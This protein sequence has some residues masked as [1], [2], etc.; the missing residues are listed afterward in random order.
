MSYMEKLTYFAVFESCGEGYSVYFPDL[1]GCISV[2]DDLESAYAGAREALGLHIYAIKCDGDALPSPSAHP[3]I[4]PETQTGYIVMPISVFPA[5]LVAEL[6]N[7]RV[8]TN[9]TIPA[10]LN[11]AAEREGIN[12]SKLL[13]AAIIDRLRLSSSEI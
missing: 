5:L 11:R 1:P 12:L 13:E 3:A 2:G 8:K 10:H 6:D 9:V 4:D 7:C